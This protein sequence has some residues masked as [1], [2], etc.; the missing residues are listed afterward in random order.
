MARLSGRALGREPPCGARPRRRVRA[1]CM[2]DRHAEADRTGPGQPRGLVPVPCLHRR[3]I[4][5]RPASPSS[6]QRAQDAEVRQNRSLATVRMPRW[7]ASGPARTRRARPSGTS[8][9][10]IVRL[11]CEAH[12][13]YPRPSRAR[14]PGRGIQTPEEIVAAPGAAVHY[15]ELP[16]RRCWVYIRT[17][18]LMLATPSGINP[19]MRHGQLLAGIMTVWRKLAV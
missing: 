5:A 12:P 19:I 16:T 9:P 7:R 3:L 1:A 11:P 6:P 4:P 8:R 13:P 17:S 15:R 14:R 2:N 18:S 10:A